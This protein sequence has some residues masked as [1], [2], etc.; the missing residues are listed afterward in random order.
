[1]FFSH[2]FS[3]NYARQV[4]ISS[5][6]F[7]EMELPTNIWKFP[8][9]RRCWFIIYSFWHHSPAHPHLKKPSTLVFQY[10][11]SSTS[12]ACALQTANLEGDTGNFTWHRGDRGR[13]GHG[14]YTCNMGKQKGPEPI[15]VNGGDMGALIYKRP[16][17]KK[18]VTI[19]LYN[20]IISGWRY[21]PPLLMAGR[22]PTLKGHK[23]PP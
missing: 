20:P 9:P 7:S 2:R 5:P 14:V 12:S 17:F 23:M 8:P 4:G 19:A 13:Q 22:G 18:Q 16:L 6:N 11:A 15:V 1:M 10:P 21:G 3:K